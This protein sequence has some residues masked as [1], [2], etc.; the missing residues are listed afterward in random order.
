MGQ[1]EFVLMQNLYRICIILASLWVLTIHARSVAVSSYINDTTVPVRSRSV[2]HR[3]IASPSVSSPTVATG[4]MVTDTIVTDSLDAGTIVTDSLDTDSIA[5]MDATEAGNNLSVQERIASLLGAEMFQKSMV[6][7]MAY[8]LT[9]DTLIFAHNER[10]LLRPASTMKLTTAITALD[11]LGGAYRYT[12]TMRYDG[13]CYETHSKRNNYI[14]DITIIGGMDPRFGT[15]DMNAFIES[16]QKERIDTIFG[17]VRADMSFKDSDR[18]GSG[19][20]WDDDNPVLTALPWNRNDQFMPKFSQ[21]IR[22]AGITVLPKSALCDSIL[23][24]AQDTLRVSSHGCKTTVSRHHTIGQILSRMMKESDN[25]YAESLFYQIAASEHKP[26]TAK[27]ATYV[28]NQLIKKIGLN[29]IDY[30]IADGSGLSLYN[31]QTAELQIQLLRYAFRNPDIYTNLYPSLPI[32][33]VDG[34]LQKRMHSGKA[35]KNVHAKTGTVTGVS[36]LSGYLTAANGNTIAFAIINQ[37][38]R[39]TSP[40]KNFQDNVCRILCDY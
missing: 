17:N 29:P 22:E 14:G 7:V 6:A 9:A 10:Q 33:G 4:I 27:T 18:L 37:G 2:S 16:L 23:S 39:A 8:D 24:M 15:D 35:Y 13:H 28:I 1:I 26:A 5:D 20:C 21:R 38:I 36:S 30:R 12:T 31:Y 11:H 40:A 3:L 25:L 19:W 34:T 32:A